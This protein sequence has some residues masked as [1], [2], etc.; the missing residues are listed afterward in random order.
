MTS[1]HNV[2][3]AALPQLERTIAL[4]MRAMNGEGTAAGEKEEKNEIPD[5]IEL[6]VMLQLCIC[7]SNRCGCFE[8]VR[9][10]LLTQ[11]EQ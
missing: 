6:D 10:Q 11:E 1:P 4:E 2:I 9:T 5:T 7:A 8:Y 3:V